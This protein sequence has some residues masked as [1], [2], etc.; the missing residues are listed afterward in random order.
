MPFPPGSYSL[1]ASEEWEA[2]QHVVPTEK[3]GFIYGAADNAIVYTYQASSNV[4]SVELAIVD[5][6]LIG[7]EE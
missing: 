5:G 7:E 2:L 1:A 6:R 3:Q 4:L